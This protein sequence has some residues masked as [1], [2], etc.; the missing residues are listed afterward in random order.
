MSVSHLEVVV[1]EV[2]VVIVR[3][4]T[5]V[6]MPVR[7]RRELQLEISTLLCKFFPFP[8]HRSPCYPPILQ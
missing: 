5:G 8:F 2:T 1:D 4:V 6:V 3:V 7:A